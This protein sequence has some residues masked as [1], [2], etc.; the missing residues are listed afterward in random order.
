MISDERF[1]LFGLGFF[2]RGMGTVMPPPEL[3]E[4]L[5]ELLLV[6][7]LDPCPAL[8]YLF[9][10]CSLFFLLNSSLTFGV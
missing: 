1:K 4:G 8:P 3:L 6:R 10:T 9:C 7:H 5:S 2:I